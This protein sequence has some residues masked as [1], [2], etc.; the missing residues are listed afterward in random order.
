MQSPEVR[1]RYLELLRNSLK[2][3][4]A[5]HCDTCQA[6]LDKN[7]LRLF[8]C[9][10]P[11]CQEILDKN[12]PVIFDSITEEDSEHFY[13]LAAILTDLGIP[14]DSINSNLIGKQ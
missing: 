6:R 5:E 12:A 3:V 11:T 14:F 10:S 1:P 2:N 4:A 7:A 13:I 9:K 8:D